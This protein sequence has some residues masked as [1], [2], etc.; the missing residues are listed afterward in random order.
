MRRIV[1]GVLWVVKGVLLAVALGALV[2]WPWSYW[3]GAYFWTGRY[4]KNNDRIDYITYTAAWR[5]GRIIVSAARGFWIIPDEEDGE[6]FRSKYKIGWM[7]ESDPQSSA[8]ATIPLDS[9]LGPIGWEIKDFHKSWRSSRTYTASCPLWLVALLAALWPLTSLTLLLRRR[10]RRRRLAL[11][12]CCKNCGYDL[13]ATP[14]SG[15]QLVTRCPECG[16][17]TP[18]AAA[19]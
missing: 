1:R 16:T 19:L 7:M 8:Y 11:T 10:A 12:G 13:R 3:R 15:G 5:D 17:A 6:S 4:S 2:V 9:S 18:R 14:H